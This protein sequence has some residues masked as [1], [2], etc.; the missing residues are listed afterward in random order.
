MKKT[1]FLKVCAFAAVALFATSCSEETL[2]I[3]GGSITVPE[4]TLPAPTA[5]ISVTVVDLEA[6]KIVGKVTNVDAT[7]AIGSTM[8]VECPANE[9][10]TTAAAVEVA[11]PALANGQAINI[12]VTFYVVTLESAYSNLN[13]TWEK[14]LYETLE[15][16][17]VALSEVLIETEGWV[18][19]MY[20]NTT[21]ENIKAKF[22]YKELSGSEFVEEYTEE[23]E[24]DSKAAETT[25]E[26][27][28]NANIKFQ[29]TKITK[30]VDVPAWNNYN[31]KSA[32]RSFVNQVM[33]IKDEK[34][35]PIYKF[36]IN[37]CW[38]TTFEAELIDNNPTH[39][40]HDNTN[41]GHDNSHNGH[42]HGNGNA[43]GGI[44]S[45]EGE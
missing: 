23:V 25:Y 35:E 14:T 24:V 38:G 36:L 16:K 5:S 6:G 22:A 2:D 42:G 4:F 15:E 9:G 31:I 34:G 29:E 13:I 18:N 8:T 17:E 28:L 40:G 43:G 30:I 41:N 20:K 39:D 19:G 26:E 32:K 45:N 11:V 10:Y 12:P 44:S 27:I 21:N 1:N 7:A 33:V 37:T 3:N